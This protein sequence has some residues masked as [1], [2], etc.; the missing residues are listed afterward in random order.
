MALHSRLLLYLD[1]VARC[2]SIRKAGEQLN[3]ASTAINRQILALEEELG[4][5][6]FQRLPRKLVLTAAGEVLVAHVRQTLKDMGQARKTIDEM[7]GLHR[8][9]LVVAAM[10]GPTAAILPGAL[11]DLR[12]SHRNIRVHVQT[13]GQRDIMR[14]VQE[15]EA[16]LGIGFDLP[17]EVGLRVVVSREVQMGAVMGPHHQ[18]AYQDAVSLDDCA[19]WPL[20]VADNTMVI[21]PHLEALYA[22][23]NLRLVPSMETNSIDFMRQMAMTD[24]VITFLTPLDVM[25]EMR[26]GKLK[27]LPFRETGLWPQHLALVAHA[28][29]TNPVLQLL[30]DRIEAILPASSHA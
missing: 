26:E 28:R 13:L 15:G 11:A 19:A 30:V 5:Q 14:S 3:V 16:D 17:R 29:N 24:E 22:R 7:R 25:T 18:L 8:G 21:R 12:R 1:T 2:G 23:H 6:L 20:V 27:F 9:E 4:T 10:A